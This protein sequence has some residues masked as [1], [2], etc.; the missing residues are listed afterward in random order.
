MVECLRDAIPTIEE[1]R[2]VLFSAHLYENQQ[3]FDRWCKA[4]ESG[5]LRGTYQTTPPTYRIQYNRLARGTFPVA[6]FY[7]LHH[8]TISLQT[9]LFPPYFIVLNCGTHCHRLSPDII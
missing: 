2:N 3:L 7:S 4:L 5:V 6:P 1:L 8:F 9:V